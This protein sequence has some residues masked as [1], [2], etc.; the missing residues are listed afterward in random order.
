M[1]KKKA[2]VLNLTK[3]YTIKKL[4][5]YKDNY[6]IDTVIYDLKISKRSINN[7]LNKYNYYTNN[8]P[9]GY[10]DSYNNRLF[11]ITGQG[12]FYE[13]EDFQNSKFKKITNNLNSILKKNNFV[14]SMSVRSLYI[15]KYND[16]IFI[17]FTYHEP[18]TK[19]VG[20]EI[21]ESNL[22]NFTNLQFMSKLQV[23]GKGFFI[24]HVP[25][26]LCRQL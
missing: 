3:F 15:D 9:V 25:Y 1:W 23:L 19:C 18:E 6:K 2:E 20:L 22:S 8:S 11:F 26:L 5:L 10:L 24:S 16:K 4:N 12:S 7:I 14:K 13:V 21:A 17:S